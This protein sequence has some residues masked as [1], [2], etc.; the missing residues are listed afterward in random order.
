M[1][2]TTEARFLNILKRLSTLPHLQLPDDIKLSRP[3]IAL[4]SW[5]GTFPGSG[6]VDIAD[7]LG[8]SPPTI[9]VGI[10]RL[11]KEGWL[12]RRRD[13]EDGRSRLIYLTPKGDDFINRLRAHQTKMFKVFLSKLNQEEQETLLDLL[14]RALDSITVTQD[15]TNG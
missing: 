1:M 4:I 2:L 12:E 3:A 14:E 15:E 9:S 8:L 6:V 11:V 7:G 13:P 5:I 10:R